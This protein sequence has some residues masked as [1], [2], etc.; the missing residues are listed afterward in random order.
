MLYEILYSL[1]SL[2]RC[3]MDDEWVTISK[4]EILNKYFKCME[5]FIYI[6]LKLIEVF[7][8][9]VNGNILIDWQL[10]NE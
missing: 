2:E 9:V 10:E 4:N 7:F 3:I 5:N 1:N 8:L 6:Y